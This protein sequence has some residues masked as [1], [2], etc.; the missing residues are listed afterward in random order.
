MKIQLLDETKFE[1]VTDGI[2]RYN[3]EIKYIFKV[4][5]SKDFYATEDK[6]IDPDNVSRVYLLNNT[7]E[8]IE[9]ITGYTQ[10]KGITKQVDYV[11]SSEQVNTGT[12]EEP[13][14]ETVEEKADVYIVT[15]SK[16]DL[17]AKYKELQDTVDFLV[18]ES[19][20]M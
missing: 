20:G 12:E 13:V 10:Y 9:T 6:F 15:M 17:E 3:D 8:P 16:L 2:Q 7:E 1:L 18:I 11:I 5:T 19:L 14:Y 4:D